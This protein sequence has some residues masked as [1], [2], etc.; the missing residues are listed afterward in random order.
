VFLVGFVL[1]LGNEEAEEKVTSAD[2]ATDE[3]PTPERAPKRKRK[4]VPYSPVLATLE[5]VAAQKALLE[6]ALK[7]ASNTE[8]RMSDTERTAYEKAKREL[9]EA[10]QQWIEMLTRRRVLLGKL[11][12]LDDAHEEHEAGAHAG[13]SNLYEM[14]R[15]FEREYAPAHRQIREE[16]RGLTHGGE[17]LRQKVSALR[18]ALRKAAPVGREA[19]KP[20][21][22]RLQRD[23]LER[24]LHAVQG[25]ETFL[26]GEHENYVQ[27]L[28]IAQEEVRRL[29][30]QHA[31]YAKLTEQSELE[32]K[33]ELANAREALRLQTQ[34]REDFEMDFPDRK[35]DA[36]AMREAEQKAL[37][38]I[39]QTT[40]AMADLPPP[41]AARAPAVDADLSDPD[42][43]YALQYAL[44]ELLAH[45]R[46]ALGTYRATDTLHTLADTYQQIAKEGELLDTIRATRKG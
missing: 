19:F 4:E 14:G 7:D 21:A 10:R 25:E 15:W 3:E 40:K 13:T 45:Q 18:K 2:Q 17:E 8:A 28:A 5:E 37:A 36:T 44:R 12:T 31:E 42:A 1:L 26:L 20:G 6:E 32:T 46:E 38:L 16:L 24:E 43:C 22:P 33:A 27:E 29:E 11:E 23:D 9:D 35:R 34:K 41:A 39:E 30:R